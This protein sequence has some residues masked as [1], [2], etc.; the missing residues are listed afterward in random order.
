MIR[1][2]ETWNFQP[3][4]ARINLVVVASIPASRIITPISTAVVNGCTVQSRENVKGRKIAKVVKKIL[5]LLK[6]KESKCHANHKVMG[7][8]SPEGKGKTF[9]KSQDFYRG[10]YF[11]QTVILCNYLIYLVILFKCNNILS[12]II[13]SWKIKIRKK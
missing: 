2:E 8:Q 9:R 11:Y 6:Q 12:F 1:F 3:A 7:V 5:W 4:N 13:K 10:N